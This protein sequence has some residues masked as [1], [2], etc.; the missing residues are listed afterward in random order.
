MVKSIK[1]GRVFLLFLIGL[2]VIDLLIISTLT[3]C[4]NITS[5]PIKIEMDRLYIFLNYHLVTLSYLDPTLM[6][7]L[8][9][10]VILFQS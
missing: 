7:V 6:M 2:L 4:N 1:I 3:I 5:Y 9:R 10:S 8:A